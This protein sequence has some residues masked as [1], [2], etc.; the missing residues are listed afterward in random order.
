MQ[1]RK[2]DN[3]KNCFMI[4]GK[5]DNNI[6][7]YSKAK[8]LGFHSFN[9]IIFGYLIFCGNSN[10]NAKLGTPLMKHFS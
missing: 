2:I 7:S 6:L 3:L 4:R 9:L 1:I 5:D 10:F 8:K